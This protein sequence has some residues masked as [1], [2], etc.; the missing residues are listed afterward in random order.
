[1]GYK[2]SKADLLKAGITLFRQRGYSAVGINDILARCS[3]PKGSF[4]NFFAGKEDF[5]LEAAKLY[6]SWLA[7]ETAETDSLEHIQAPARL[8]EYFWGMKTYYAGTGFKE[9]CLHQVFAAELSENSEIM[10]VVNTAHGNRVNAVAGWITA[11]I[12]ERSISPGVFPLVAANL[13]VNGFNGALVI[14]KANH[15]SIPLDEFID[16]AIALILK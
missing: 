14:A 16:Q 2:H 13:L 10:S 9:S 1:M 11:G 15:S 12:A 3:V 6:A 5:A 8:L 7:R 4:Y